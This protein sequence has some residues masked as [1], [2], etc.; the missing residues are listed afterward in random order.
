MTRRDL[1]SNR[2]EVL[3]IVNSGAVDFATARMMLWAMDLT[4]AALPAE[5]AARL[6]RADN[7]NVSYHVPVNSLF[8]QSYVINPSQV[9]ENTREEGEG[10]TTEFA[11]WKPNPGT[12]RLPAA[13]EG[14]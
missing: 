6:R 10:G 1:A 11:T 4:A 12:C 3:R 14:C 8:S 9:T 13:P 7:P 2:A 5:P